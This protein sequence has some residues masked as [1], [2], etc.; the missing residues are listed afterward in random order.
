MA[1]DAKCQ[2][3]FHHRVSYSAILCAL[4][5]SVILASAQRNEK[6][7]CGP[8]GNAFEPQDDRMYSQYE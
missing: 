1:T 7:A 5:N 2:A 6:G 4:T 8:E 3:C